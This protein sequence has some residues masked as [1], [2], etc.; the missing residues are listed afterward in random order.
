MTCQGGLTNPPP[1]P[2]IP[3]SSINSMDRSQF[4]VA[5]QQIKSQGFIKS[6]Y[7]GDRAVG[8]MLELLLNI[9]ENNS[10]D[11]D[12]SFGD[13]KA[14]DENSSSLQT[15]MTC[16]YRAWQMK[17]K[18]VLAKYGYVDDETGHLALRTTFKHTPNNRGFY[19]DASDD[20]Y[21]YVKNIDGT[22]ILKWSWD[23]LLKRFQAKLHGIVKVYAESEIRGDGKYFH[24]KN[25]YIL[26]C[27]DSKKL[28][29][30]YQS[31]ENLYIDIRCSYK[32]NKSGKLFL[33]NHGTAFRIPE[34]KIGLIFA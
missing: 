4:D 3:A 34:S 17:T 27:T 33:K 28:K 6:K 15:L 14:C 29:E 11:S 24:Y 13:V 5:F 26:N 9:E 30:A 10:K 7:N 31:D 2:R 12:L 1:C 22:V 32:Y 18:D 23:L 16:D 25:Y 20:D 8:A 21:L 19:Y